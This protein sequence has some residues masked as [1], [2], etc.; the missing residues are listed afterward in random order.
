MFSAKS[1]YGLKLVL[2]LAKSQCQI[3]RLDVAKRQGIPPDYI[4]HISLKLK[5]AGIIDT[6]RGKGGGLILAQKP[7]AISVWAVLVAMGEPLV[8][9]LCLDTSGCVNEDVCDTKDAWQ[10]VLDTIRQPL[11]QLTIAELLILTEKNPKTSSS[12]EVLPECKGPNR[13]AL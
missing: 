10:A 3:S 9:V 8:P 2:E 12:L 6:H 11:G 5:K 1:R 7:E 4:E 13:L